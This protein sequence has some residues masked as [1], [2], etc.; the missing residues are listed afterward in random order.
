MGENWRNGVK[1]DKVESGDKK[2]LKR[3]NKNRPE[4][5]S[6]R[7]PKGWKKPAF[8]PYKIKKQISRDPRF[9]ALCGTEFNQDVFDKRYGFLDDVLKDEI[10]AL[11]KAA[12]KQK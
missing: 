3:K 9:D 5:C 6:S 7:R 11:Q 1:K 4:E 2:K 8:Q 12:K 10:K